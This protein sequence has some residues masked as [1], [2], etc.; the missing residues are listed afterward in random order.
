MGLTGVPLQIQKQLDNLAAYRAALT[1]AVTGRTL[2]WQMVQNADNPT[3]ENRVFGGY[4]ISQVDTA[5]DS[6]TI[7]QGVAPWFAQHNSYFQNDLAITGVGFVSPLDAWLAG[8]RWR[9]SQYLN[10]V[11]K[12]VSGSYLTA[13]NVFPRD[14][15][16]LGSHAKTSDVFTAGS[17]V[18]QTQSGLGRVM[19]VVPQGTTIGGTNY[20]VTATLTRATGAGLSLAV[21]F[22][23]GAIA[24]AAITYG[25][26]ALSGTAASGQAVVPVAATAQFLVGEYVCSVIPPGSPS[27]VRSPAWSPTPRSPSPPT[28]STPIRPGTP[29]RWHRCSPGLPRPPVVAPGLPGTTSFSRSIPIESWPSTGLREIVSPSRNGSM[30]SGE[31]AVRRAGPR[32]RL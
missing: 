32:L 8:Q 3:Y 19:A 14:D 28:S 15:L 30:R 18:D 26:Q 17:P 2:L 22:S 31:V 11:Q 9:V 10:R 13:T 27:G 24:G 5:L 6:V 16:A 29:R 1:Q 21:T 4:T 12:D 23:S 7:S 25:S 20:T